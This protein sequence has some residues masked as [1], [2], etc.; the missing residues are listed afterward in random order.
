MGFVSSLALSHFRSHQN[1]TLHLDSRPIA[2]MGANGSGKTNILE[3]VSL[4]SPGRGL[5]R[6]A[7]HSMMRYPENLGWKITA[8]T[9]TEDTVNEIVTRSEQGAAR[10]VKIDGKNM[11]QMKLGEYLR[12]L[13]LIPAMDRLWIE[14][15]EGR[16]RF[17]DRIALS[18]F[19]RH[20]QNTIIYEKAMRERNRLLKEQIRD[21]AWYLALEKQMATSGQEI[22]EARTQAVAYIQSAQDNGGDD[23][24]HALL[25]LSVAEGEVLATE[26]DLSAALS[27]SRARDLMAGRTLVGPHKVDLTGVYAAKDIPAADC[28]TGE[29]KALLVSIIIAN[30]RAL[31]QVHN[32]SPLIL[33]DEVSAHLDKARRASLYAAITDLGLQAWLT[34]TE[35]EIF[36]EFEADAQYVNVMDVDGSSCIEQTL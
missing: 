10:D 9:S 34:G 25:S 21:P 13:W 27:A 5:R 3:A 11:S 12:V 22:M 8:T 33:L 29:Q 6:A 18:F 35:R 1:T 19:A 32:I 23:F 15:S 14:S 20:A 17:L 36:Q 24:P 4:L 28:S 31:R 16:R 2:I 26:S 7:A 30:A